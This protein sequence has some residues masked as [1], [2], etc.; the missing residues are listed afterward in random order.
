MRRNGFRWRPLPVEAASPV[1]AN[2]WLTAKYLSQ[3]ATS[4]V[5]AAGRDFTVSLPGYLR[6]WTH[7]CAG[8]IRPP[9][10]TGV[11]SPNRLELVVTSNGGLRASCPEVHRMIRAGAADQQAIETKRRV[12][13]PRSSPRYT[14][15]SKD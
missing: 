12:S 1:F 7:A 4:A 13:C 8:S 9:P 3:G 6:R 5:A 10:L 11:P 15:P 14:S 2:I